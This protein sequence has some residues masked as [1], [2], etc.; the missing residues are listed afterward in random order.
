MMSEQNLPSKYDINWE[1]D[2]Y[3][4]WMK[5]NLFS[6]E[7]VRQYQKENNFNINQT[8]SISLPP[9]NV[10]GKLHLW[11][12]MM[13]AVEDAM[14]RY[15]RMQG[16]DTIWIPGTDHAGISTQVVVEKKLFKDEWKTRHDIGREAFLDKVWTWVK[17]H[18]STIV[19]Q[20]KAMWSSLDRDRE[21]FTMSERLSRAVR[22]SFSIL[23][24]QDKIYHD[25]YIINWCPRCQTVLSDLEAIYKEKEAKLY[26]LKYFIVDQNTSDFIT[27]ATIRPETI[28]WDVAIA[29]HPD[30]NRYKKFIWQKVTIPLTNR[31]I[32]VI[33]DEYVDIDFWTWALKITPCHDPHDFEIW[34]KHKLPLDLFA[35]DKTWKYTD[36]AWW[37]SN[38]DVKQNMDK[39]FKELE[40]MW[41]LL[42]SE[43]YKSKVPECDRCSTRIE[44]M[45]S[46]QW[47]VDVNDMA[48][49]SIDTVNTWKTK[50]H[51]QRF[52]KMFFNWMDNIRPWCISR[53]LRW[54][55]RIPVW[56]CQDC[57][58]SHVLDEDKLLDL[59]SKKHE[60][61]YKILTMI[62]FNLIA[63]SR[64]QNKFSID[65]LFSLLNESSL[66]P[67]EG[68]IREV[69][70]KMYLLKFSNDS[71]TIWELEEFKTIMKNNDS[72]TLKEILS[73]NIWIWYENW[74]FYI[75]MRCQKCNSTNLK[76]DP[77]VL[78]TWYS[79]WLWPFSILGWPENTAD[80]E[81]YY[82]NTVLET[83]WDILW[84][85]VVRM[86]FQWLDMM[87]Q[88]PF[89]NVYLHWL[90]KDEK[91]QKMSKS[92]WNWI[93]PIDIIKKYWSDA[94]RL[95][96]LV[97]STPWNDIKFAEDRVEYFW[98]FL[99]KLWNATRFVLM[100]TETTE[101]INYEELRQ[102]I[103]NNK[104]ELGD[105]DKWILDKIN[106][107]I[108]K[109]DEEM[110][111]FM[112]WEF[113]QRIIDLVWHD[114]CDWYIEVS[115]EKYSK[116]TNTVLLYA[117]S[118]QLKLLHPFIPHVTEK[119][120]QNIP[121]T[122]FL[123]IQEAAKEINIGEV[124]KKIWTFM[125][126]IWA[127]RNLRAEVNLKPNETCDIYFAWDESHNKF[128]KKHENILYKLLRA[129]SVLY[130]EV[131]SDEY[132][133]TI[134]QWYKLWLKWNQIVD[135]NE[136]MI[137]LEKELDI[138]KRFAMWTQK[139]LNDETFLSKAP[140]HIIEQR[141]QSLLETKNTIK[142][143]EEEIKNVKQKI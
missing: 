57:Q 114:F 24:K 100:K 39:L 120:W 31:T 106:K 88:E 18:R 121:M 133:V 50:F 56:H 102:K 134:L 78:D 111:K 28:F 11:H 77:D 38:K 67:Q 97:W 65:K 124:D 138:K 30:D 42:K 127:Y 104:E 15:A 125:D 72:S 140:S 59:L 70:T 66:T 16:K 68:K 64:L 139:Q 103:E 80:L 126:A 116:L 43:N 96:L 75:D 63:D 81:K 10:T 8:F 117:I 58:E 60:S 73:K 1:H 122:W 49:K 90:V 129:E 141:K 45:V 83:W 9:P 131:I 108:M 5:H 135:W 74:L 62:S 79:S 86:M 91:G 84:F 93:D 25:T 40:D 2:I 21:Q 6:P 76:Q 55:H 99:N 47:F 36:L 51:P 109:A 69:Y 71:N 123:M 113:A 107:L 23:A 61:K 32:P 115:K 85:R 48:K 89:S 119:I 87:W 27:V 12:A 20:I 142:I 44:P 130:D 19:S 136:K 54:W 110:D 46:Q 4:L 98:K 128:I 137:S 3:D 33:S 22:K 94:L 7:V 41:F 118:T 17:E 26:Y 143:L 34:S 35:F 29:V 82:P 95:W 92:K 37:Y 14:I 13:L 52:N 105:F 53:Q 101:N 112:L 132:T